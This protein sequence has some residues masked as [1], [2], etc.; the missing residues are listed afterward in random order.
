MGK[1]IRST[2][3]KQTRDFNYIE[4]LVDGFILAGESDKALGQLINLGSGREIS[5]KDL[6]LMIHKE[7]NSS[8]ELKIGDLEYRPTEIWR[9][10]ADN[11]RAKELLNWTP[12]VS[13]EEGL[14]HTIKWYKKFLEQYG[15][16]NSPLC[17]L[18]RFVEESRVNN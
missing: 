16:K 18:S 11:K 12:K 2:E 9:M 6:I 5:I 13:F 8:S 10:V 3:G 1:T 14:R 4:N 15:N 17:E 7:T